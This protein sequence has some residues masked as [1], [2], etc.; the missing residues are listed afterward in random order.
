MSVLSFI[1]DEAPWME[2]ALCAQIDPEIFYP[3]DSYGG[4]LGHKQV[5]TA[6]AICESCPVKG[7]CLEYGMSEEW[8]IWGGLTAW[9]RR[10][11]TEGIA[12]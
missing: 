10:T 1:Y 7:E 9:E 8:G 2:Q 4:V 3:E 5:A 6:K 12:S 11:R